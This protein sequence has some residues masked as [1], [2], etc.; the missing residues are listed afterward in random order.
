MRSGPMM[1]KRTLSWS[2]P[3]A[4]FRSNTF[5]DDPWATGA[6]QRYRLWLNTPWSLV[7]CDLTCWEALS[8]SHLSQKQ[9]MLFANRTSL[10][11][12]LDTLKSWLQLIN[13]AC[14]PFS[15]SQFTSLAPWKCYFMSAG[16]K[17]IWFQTCPMTDFLLQQRVLS[18]SAE[19][20]T[21]SNWH[22]FMPCSSSKRHIFWHNNLI[23]NLN[24]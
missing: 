9:T 8:K 10:S 23:C 16:S 19:F 3:S 21:E 13:W 11:S 12:L 18:D 5:C 22:Q 6:W 7:L 24:L 14:P 4:T 2:S 15:V 17:R 1:C 20:L